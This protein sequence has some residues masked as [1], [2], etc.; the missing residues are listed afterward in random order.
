MREKKPIEELGELLHKGWLIKQSISKNISN[1]T[2]NEIYDTGRKAGAIGGKITG[3]G[4]GGF[5]LLFVPPKNQLRV[6][7]K[8]SKLIHVPF[9]FEEA[10]SQ[11]IFHKL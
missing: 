11:V 9:D 5:I 10:G 3:A 7:E 4:G 2:I 8:L 1:P 6:K